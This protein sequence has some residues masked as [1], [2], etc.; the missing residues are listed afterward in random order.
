MS[1][2]EYL[3]REARPL[4]E[5]VVT[6][7]FVMELGDGTLLWDKFK[8]YF[9][10]DHVFL[11]D[12]ISLLCLAITKAPDFDAARKLSAFMNLVLGGRR[13]YSRTPSERWACPRR[14]SEI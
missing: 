14:R 2:A 3:Q 7:P 13:G 6:H 11:R 10:Q 1:L 8:V 5:K 9:Q 12:W 4:W